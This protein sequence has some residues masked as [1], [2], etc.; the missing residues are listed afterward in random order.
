MEPIN[1]ITYTAAQSGFL[2]EKGTKNIQKIKFF[3]LLPINVFS[4]LKICMPT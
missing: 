3:L 2:K 1:N 4:Y